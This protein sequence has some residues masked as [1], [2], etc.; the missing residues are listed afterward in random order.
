MLVPAG[1]GAVPS[2]GL[3]AE[4]EPVSGVDDPQRIGRR[5]HRR[6]Q[7][8]TEIDRTAV[9]AHLAGSSPRC[10]SSPWPS[11]PDESCCPST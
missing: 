7:P 2:E 4:P 5:E 1:T 8:A 11:D 6:P 3:G 9:V 10:V